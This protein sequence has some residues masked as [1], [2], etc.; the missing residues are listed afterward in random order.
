MQ[1][2]GNYQIS[3]RV[4]VPKGLKRC[5]QGDMHAECFR[6]YVLGFRLWVT[7]CGLRASIIQHPEPSLQYPALWHLKF[8]VLTEAPAL[9]AGTFDTSS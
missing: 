5:I 9:F 4:G 8:I 3:G 6:F 1:A 2:R 7:V